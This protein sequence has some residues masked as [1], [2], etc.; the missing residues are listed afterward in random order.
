MIQNLVHD[1][2]LCT[3]NIKIF[4]CSKLPVE[5]ASILMCTDFKL[6]SRKE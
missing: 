3:L 2:L 4:I 6:L 5:M 1:K